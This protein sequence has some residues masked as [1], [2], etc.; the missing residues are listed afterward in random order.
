[1]PSRWGYRTTRSY[2][3]APRYPRV[4]VKP[5]RRSGLVKKIF[6]IVLAF[7]GGY[8]LFWS[9]LFSIRDVQVRGNHA[10]PTEQITAAVET[11]KLE[12]RWFFIPQ[13][14][15][16]AFEEKTLLKNVSDPRLESLLVARQPLGTLV[17]TVQEKPI[18]ALWV[19]QQ[20]LFQLDATGDIIAEISSVDPSAVGGVRIE[21][22]ADPALPSVGNNV[23]KSSTLSRIIDIQ[24]FFPAALGFTIQKF[25][26]AKLAEGDLMATTSRGWVIHFSNF[27][28]I[29]EQVGKLESFVVQKQSSN[30]NW[31]AKLSYIDLRFGGSRVYYRDN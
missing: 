16:L 10:I 30:K 20:R 17:V 27:N 22:S 15:I 12:H 7:L 31:D 5:K 2:E 25:D 18:A 13:R 9:P 26:I 29:E 1:M 8:I 21:N 24:R 4:T 19:S 6:S 23:L 14:T 3:T 11:A 28:D